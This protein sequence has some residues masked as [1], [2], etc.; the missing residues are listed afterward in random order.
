[1][2]VC[3]FYYYLEMS[4]FFFFFCMEFW[5]DRSWL[6][7][8]F[9]VL[10][11]CFVLTPLVAKKKKKKKL[12]AANLLWIWL[13]MISQSLGTTVGEATEPESTDLAKYLGEWFI[14]C[15]NLEMFLL[16]QWYSKV[17][18]GH[19]V[20][21]PDGK[22]LIL[23]ERHV[24]SSSVILYVCIKRCLSSCLMGCTAKSGRQA[25]LHL[26]L[27]WLQIVNIFLCLLFL[28]NSMC[29]SHLGTCWE[30]LKP[31]FGKNKKLPH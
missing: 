3:S 12:A 7:D 11:I 31:F 14:S 4:F 27:Y 23:V 2:R 30:W 20:M 26:L 9:C 29:Q 8:L 19:L 5:D 10:S 28:I 1:M 16:P 6:L 24:T 21:G 17:K 15:A 25:C 18:T 13:V 22:G